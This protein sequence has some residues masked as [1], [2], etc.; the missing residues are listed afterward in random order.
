MPKIHIRASQCAFIASLDADTYFIVDSH[1]PRWTLT[2]PSSR[3]MIVFDADVISQEPFESD[4]IYELSDIVLSML[5]SC[6][7]GVVIISLRPTK[8]SF[9]HD[10]EELIR[11]VSDVI[12]EEKTAFHI[13]IGES[14][15]FKLRYDHWARMVPML[16]SDVVRVDVSPKSVTFTGDD[17]GA[18]CTCETD[19]E[20]T[21]QLHYSDW[22]F[23]FDRWPDRF[24]HVQMGIGEN[25][26]LYMMYGG[27][28]GFMSPVV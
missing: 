13:P 16:V 15:S 27:I 19:I 21:F 22:K 3:S 18:A 12:D 26:V 9:T 28:K 20:T 10:H 11:R 2:S 14:Q 23:I 6:A 5:R 24:V 4:A 7:H 8:V 1:G 25:G 17:C